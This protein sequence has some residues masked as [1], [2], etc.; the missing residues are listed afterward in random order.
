VI[1]PKAENATLTKLIFLMGH[2]TKT[3]NESNI[4]QKFEK[5]NRADRIALAAANGNRTWRA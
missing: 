5:A 1:D 2:K 4:S 3:K